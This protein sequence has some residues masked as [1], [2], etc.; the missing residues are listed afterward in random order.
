[1]KINQI[2]NDK[3]EIILSKED[4]EFNKISFHALMSNSTQ[5]QKLFLSM[6]EFAEKEIGFKTH[7][8]DV[9]IETIALN[10]S[11][12]ILTI[13]RLKKFNEFEIKK[14][15]I[16]RKKYDHSN[17][18][19]FKNFNDFY[20]FYKIVKFSPDFAKCLFFFNNDFYY[21]YN[22]ENKK[23]SKNSKLLLAEFAVPSQIPNS[24]IKNF[25]KQIY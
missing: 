16:G 10:N 7:N 4:L 5:S 17:T 22:E 12:F 2:E 25:G 1:M 8:Y 13:T 14:F 19:K 6:L 18:Y 24:L 11:D 21:I 9:A 20:D 23:N 3:I 15:K